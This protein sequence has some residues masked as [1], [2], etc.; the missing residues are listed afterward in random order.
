MGKTVSLIFSLFDKIG[1]KNTVFVTESVA[2]VIFLWLFSV[3]LMIFFQFQ[4]LKK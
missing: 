4:S 2:E 3:F 1:G